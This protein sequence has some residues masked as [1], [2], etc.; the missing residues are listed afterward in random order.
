[1]LN[2]GPVRAVGA[3]ID[4][5][6]EGV[7]AAM[8]E[9]DGEAIHGFGK[10][11]FRPFAEDERRVLRAAR[12]RWGAHREA[13]E[14]VENAQ[15]E[16]LA[17]FPQA[18]IIGLHGPVLAH[19]PG[20]RGSLQPGN[21][22]LLA[23]ALGRPVV[24]DLAATDIEMGGQGAPLAPFFHFACARRI[25]AGG[26]LAFL[27]LDAITTVTLVDPAA[28]RP[29]EGGVLLAWEAGPGLAL[30]VDLL[31][32]RRGTPVRAGGWM[33]AG[34]R[35]D[36]D[37][38]AAF[39][40]DPHHFRLPPRALRE[41]RFASLIEAV[42]ALPEEDAMATLTAAVEAALSQSLAHLPRPPVQAV[43]SGSGRRD[44]VLMGMLGDGPSFALRRAEEFGL[45]GDMMAAQAMAHLAVRV[46]RGLPT[47][48]PATTGVAA[49]IGG[50]QI[51]RPSGRSS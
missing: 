10:A 3:V 8:I 23:G 31:A 28:P 6:L 11:A 20:G 41:R 12:G 49:A 26:P 42:A 33:E 48:C 13:A 40:R 24:W 43:V 32:E 18:E 51:S 21:G 37:A 14:I 47:T 15:A 30:L 44:A 34:G 35:I 45:D 25:G 27:D 2:R 16:V 5:A 36:T 50:G 39:L 9:T 1:M 38:L 19:E 7:A 4:I 29:E 46:V 22:A 17:G